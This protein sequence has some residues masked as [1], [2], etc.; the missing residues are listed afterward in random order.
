MELVW[1]DASPV[2]GNTL[3]RVNDGVPKVLAPLVAHV[4]D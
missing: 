3:S 2:A 4:P 1:L